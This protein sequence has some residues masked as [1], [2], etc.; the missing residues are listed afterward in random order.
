MVRTT[1]EYPFDGRWFNRDGIRMHYLDEGKG[2]PVV[3][4]HGN[5][6]WSYY[7]RHLAVALRDSHRCIVPDHIGMGRSDKPTDAEYRYTLAERIADIE[8][9]LDYLGIT[10]RI[11]LVLHDW[12]GAIGMGYA[13]RHP[14]RIARIVLLNTGAFHLPGGKGFPKAL[15]LTRTPLGAFLVRGFNAFSWT[16]ARVCCTRKKL[17]P[18]QRRAYTRPYNSWRNRIATLRFV[19]D[20]PLRPK[21]ASYALISEM[22]ES[23]SKFNDTPALICWGLKDFVFDH[24]FLEEWERHWPHAE[25]HRFED[26]GHY[27]LEDARDEVIAHIQRF[28][29]AHPIPEADPDS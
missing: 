13:A 1:T 27:I 10:E 21:D 5:P 3:M 25:V 19:Q 2:D 26:C 7:Y 12:G 24:H 22:Q 23:L 29:E 18:M 17:T 16:A 9:L 15:W 14:E 8:K 11:T 20:I 4:L 6:S 28:L